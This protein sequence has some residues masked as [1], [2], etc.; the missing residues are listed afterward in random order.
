M[1]AASYL[2]IL[3]SLEAIIIALWIPP[4]KIKE[5]LCIWNVTAARLADLGLSLTAKE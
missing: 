3:G 1:P 4:D 2:L 5:S